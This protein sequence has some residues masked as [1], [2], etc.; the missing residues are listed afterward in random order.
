MSEAARLLLGTPHACGY[1]SGREARSA[2]IDPQFTLNPPRYAELLK[3]GFRRSGAYVYRPACTACR[4]CRPVRVAVAG[5]KPGRTQ[6]RCLKHNSDLVLTR[7]DSLGEEHFSLYRD[8]LSARHPTGG[9]DPE[10]RE[11][12]HSFLECRWGKTEVWD[13]RTGA[14]LLATALVDVLPRALSAVYTFFDPAEPSRSLGTLA[15]LKQ[16]EQARI[17]N[18][19]HVYLGYWV[20]HSRKMTYKRNF[21][22]LEMLTP[23]GWQPADT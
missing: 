16:I 2:F 20:E 5:F 6:Q 15:V 12:F 22:P 10:D 3:M 18:L 11:A 14:R 7:S 23:Q 9:M 4:E 21:K 1:L 19:D 17:A 13:F 8:Y